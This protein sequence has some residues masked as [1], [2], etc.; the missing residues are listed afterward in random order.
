MLG[1]LGCNKKDLLEGNSGGEN[2]SI[3]YRIVAH[4]NKGHEA[5]RSLYMHCQYY[6][7]ASVEKHLDFRPLK[8]QV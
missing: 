6:G 2:T 8:G 5:E 3:R 4:L 1:R 7:Q